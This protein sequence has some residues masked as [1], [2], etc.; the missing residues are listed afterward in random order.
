MKHTIN[1]L[2][3]SDFTCTARCGV[4]G[5]VTGTYTLMMTMC[6]TLVPIPTMRA[7]ARESGSTV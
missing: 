1:H 6:E 7:Q 3:R 2:L 4:S 5:L